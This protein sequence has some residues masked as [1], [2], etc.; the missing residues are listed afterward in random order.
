MA[1]L[2]G[3]TDPARGQCL[4]E[5]GK[6]L[7]RTHQALLY[8]PQP[9]L[10]GGGRKSE[11]NSLPS[12]MGVTHT[13]PRLTAGTAPPGG[14]KARAEVGGS[15]KEAQPLQEGVIRQS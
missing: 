13:P 7:M 3:T 6:G 15:E 10:R 12:S 4:A 11:L 5:M 9:S 2:P 8:L 1:L 14:R